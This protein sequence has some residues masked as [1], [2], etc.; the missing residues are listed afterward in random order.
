MRATRLPAKIVRTA[1]SS[2]APIHSPGGKNNIWFPTGATEKIRRAIWRCCKTWIPEQLPALSDV[3]VWHDII[4]QECDKLTLDQVAVF[5]EE[6]DTIEKLASELQ[7]KDAHEWLMEIYATLKLDEPAFQAAINKRS[8][9][10]NHN[11]TF[12][13]KAELF[14]HASDIHATVMAV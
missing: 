9:L 5:I 1:A 11:A 14:R 6:D 8:I 12:N 10:P 2:L 3:E 7:E 4:W 13:R